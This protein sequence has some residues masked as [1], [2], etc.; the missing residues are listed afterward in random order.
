MFRSIIPPLVSKQSLNP[1]EAIIASEIITATIAC[2]KI[3]SQFTVRLCSILSHIIQKCLT[4][5]TL[6]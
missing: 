4:W 6:L 2:D 5:E 3:T 1:R